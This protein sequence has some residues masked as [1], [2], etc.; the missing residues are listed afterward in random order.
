MTT[1][2]LRGTVTRVT[3]ERDETGFRVVRVAVD[4]GVEE[5]VVGVMPRVVRGSEVRVVGR[6]VDDP[7]FGKQIAVDSVTPVEPQ[8][9]EGFVRFISGLVK[10]I[11]PRLAERVVEHFGDDAMRVL[12]EDPGR[13]AEVRGVSARVASSAA[14]AWV[15]A[16]AS[17]AHLSLLMGLGLPRGLAYRVVK[18]FGAATGHVVEREPYRLSHEVPGIGFLTA[19][20]LARRAGIPPT[21]EPRLDAGVVH[22]LGEATE[23]GHTVVE[24]A[25]I[26]D[27]A[28]EVLE[29]DAPLLDGALDRA[30]ARGWVVDVGA[31]AVSP[32]GLADAEVRVA[33]RLAAL[34]SARVAKVSNADGALAEYE[35][36]SR[37]SL[38]PEQRAAVV[39]AA[40][41][42]VLVVTGGPG[43]GKTTIV[44]AIVALFE[45]ARL[46]VRLAA[47]TGRAAKRLAEA[48]E[49]PALTLH[50][51]LEVD[52]RSGGFLRGAG[53]PLDGDVFVIDEASMIDVP[54]GAA[55]LD[56]V[57]DGARVVLVGDVD[58]LP[59][60]GPGALLR[61]L[62]D[63]VPTTRLSTI[64]RQ[65]QGSLIVEGAH[66]I[67][68]GLVPV[69]SRD[70]RGDFF[71]IERAEPAAARRT[72]AH[73]VT[74]RLPKAFGLDPMRD[75]QVLAPMKKGECGTVA[76]NAEL[77]ARLNPQPPDADPE[78]VA[79]GDK[80]MQL[81]NDYELDV[82]NGDLGVV[83]RRD[84]TDGTLL[85]DMDERRVTYDRDAEASLGLAYATSIHKSQG[86][87]Y[88][89]V[90]IPW[91]RSHWVML[92]RNLLY[93]AVTRGK[94]VVVIVGDPSAI[95]IA[96]SDARD[97]DRRTRLPTLLDAIRTSR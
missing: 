49:R 5:L 70:E 34:L 24:R 52:P 40:R 60:V 53:A 83:A 58:Q 86:S 47:P 95:E 32:R 41:E 2:T 68:A 85:V 29:V 91:L 87:E 15:D 8:G 10:G 13:L 93:T 64:F 36:R 74:E 62:L 94:R 56:A 43:V 42:R 26:E 12:D 89:A 6:R 96:L 19:D 71:V 37:L 79:P 92:S 75:I 76:L 1:V 59:S 46:R 77:R 27:R 33:G 20:R 54:L 67:R 51:L 65:A 61:D 45:A 7:R 55:L 11:G 9:R 88:P 31:G 84:D 25:A 81:R 44:R 69:A 90:V 23:R 80:V 14:I 38:A 30:I 48:T 16:R 39:A 72:I 66:R 28:A 4:G 78:R 22:V 82:Y 3:F 21:A 18:R 50:R 73:V 35:R 17:A 97:E 63:R 57:P